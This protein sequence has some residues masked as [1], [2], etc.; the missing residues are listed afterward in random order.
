[1]KEYLTERVRASQTPV[2]GRNATREYLQARVL[3]ALQRCGAMIPLAFHGGTALR[4]LYASPRY[5]EALDFALERPS[6]GY[7]FRGYLRGAG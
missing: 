4:F 6:S 2:Q 1:M 7:D 3:G 5:S